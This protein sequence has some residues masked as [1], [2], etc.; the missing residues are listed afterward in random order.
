MNGK[1]DNRVKSQVSWKQFS[2][3]WDLVFKKKKEKKKEGAL[4]QIKI[5]M[6]D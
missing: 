2:D 6:K 5:A 1:G 4:C 3:N